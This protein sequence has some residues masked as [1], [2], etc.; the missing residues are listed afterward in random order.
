MTQ[1]KILYAHRENVLT[2]LERRIQDE[3]TEAELHDWYLSDLKLS[4]TT[5]NEA[6]VILIFRAD[7]D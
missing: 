4:F 5:C 6:F 2:D 1:V 3:I 7:A